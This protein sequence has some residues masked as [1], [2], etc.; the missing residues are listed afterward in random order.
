MRPYCN[1]NQPDRRD[2]SRRGTAAVEFAVMMPLFLMLV[3]GTWEMGTALTAGTKMAAAV[4]EGGRLASMDFEKSLAPGQTANEKVEAD[5][6]NFLTASGIPGDNVTVSITHAD[7]ASAGSPFD[8]QDPDNYLELFRIT[9]S[10]DY[11][12]VGS[13]P[14]EYM[15]GQTLEESMIFRMGRV[16]LSN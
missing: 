2:D 13:F 1:R 8:L 16:A 3:L 12:S 11:E 10:T 6:K 7:G 5:I 15:A 9:V 14:L 4:R